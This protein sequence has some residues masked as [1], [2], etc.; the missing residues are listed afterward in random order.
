[1]K[2]MKKILFKISIVFFICLW[3]PVFTQ[4]VRADNEIPATEFEDKLFYNYCVNLADTNKDGILTEAEAELQQTIALDAMH[5]GEISSLKGME[6]FKNLTQVSVS[7]CPVTDISYIQELASLQSLW[8]EK[9]NISD[10]S[11]LKSM[12]QLTTLKL[13][14]NENITD[15]SPVQYAVNVQVLYLNGADISD[16]SMLRKCKSLVEFS[17][18]DAML[19]DISVLEQCVE[20]HSLCLSN[21]QFTTIP[22]LTELTQLTTLMLDG[23][24]LTTETLLDLENLL[25][26][27][28]THLS[29]WQS[30]VLDEDQINQMENPEDTDF[31][32]EE[33]TDPS[34]EEDTPVAGEEPSTAGEEDLSSSDY[35]V[36][37]DVLGSGAMVSGNIDDGVYFESRRIYDAATVQVAAA[38]VETQ[39]SG[40][41]K[42]EVYDMGLYKRQMENGVRVKV[43]PNG[44]VEVSVPISYGKGMA[45]RVWHQEADGSYRELKTFLKD[46]EIHFYTDKFSI[47]V[48]VITKLFG[49]ETDGD[50]NAV[51][52]GGT[53][54]VD[55]TVS[56]GVQAQGADAVARE[57]TSGYEEAMQESVKNNMEQKHSESHDKNTSKEATGTDGKS[58]GTDSGTDGERSGMGAGRAAAVA[59]IVLSLAGT[60]I[61]TRVKDIGEF[62]RSF[63]K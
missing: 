33:T 15:Y 28:I 36:L 9:S 20:L 46:G 58:D 13:C 25:P 30:S 56:S 34:G 39:V 27:S 47:F 11:F 6:Y 59:V 43:Q 18:I 35:K 60:V 42:L 55:V 40:I 38:Y 8:I 57:E 61:F 14:Y 26:E 50:G 4:N 2:I 37:E 54:K 16:I 29:D 21:N 32:E 24:P 52:S 44:T 51:A 5:H 53:E 1:M 22:D 63:R 31:S 17:A 10:I 41:E 3:L 23:N 19:T 7:G 49:G 45:G 62:I 48:L 12:T